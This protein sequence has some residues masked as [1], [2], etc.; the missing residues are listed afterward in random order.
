MEFILKVIFFFAMYCMLSCLN[1][2]SSASGPVAS[3]NHDVVEFLGK[4]CD[5]KQSCCVSSSPAIFG[6][7]GTGMSNYIRFAYSCRCISKLSLQLSTREQNTPT[8]LIT[9]QNCVHFQYYHAVSCP[10]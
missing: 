8:L 3:L 2:D 9:E 5:G 1:I 7:K 6:I 10:S 4:F